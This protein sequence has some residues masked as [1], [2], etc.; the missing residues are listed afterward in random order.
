MSYLGAF[1]DIFRSSPIILLSSKMGKAELVRCLTGSVVRQG[2]RTSSKNSLPSPALTLL[3][4]LQICESDALLEI[5]DKAAPS[6]AL[7]KG[8]AVEFHLCK[9][10]TTIIISFISED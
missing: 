2:L 10:V 8:S 6:A 7:F 3:A 1:S 4:L 9:L 5:K